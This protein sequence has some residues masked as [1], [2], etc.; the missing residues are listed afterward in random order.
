MPCVGSSTPSFS[1][2]HQDEELD[3][4]RR[5]LAKQRDEAVR[6]ADWDT[7][8]QEPEV[9]QKRTGAVSSSEKVL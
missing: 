1:Y 2:L 5:T 3:N 9:P 7:M 4:L 6:E 8:E